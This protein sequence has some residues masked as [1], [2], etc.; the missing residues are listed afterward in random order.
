MLDKE[1]ES[2]SAAELRLLA[3]AR[4]AFSAFLNLHFLN[5][6]DGA[7][8]DEIRSAGYKS[9]LEQFAQD[10]DVQAEISEGARLMLEFIVGNAGVEAKQ[11]SETLGIDRTRLY[12][13]VSPAYGP[14]PPYE[15]EWSGDSVNLPEFLQKLA[16]SYHQDGLAGA[17][18]THDRL[19]YVGVEL[20]YVEF[21]AQQEAVQLESGDLAAA[22]QL[23]ERQNLFFQGHLVA[24]VPKFVEKALEYARTDFY[25]G[26][27]H[28]LRGFLLEQGGLLPLLLS[29]AGE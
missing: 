10:V 15:A 4:A 20:A 1:D 28:M 13:G 8:V 19:D 16:R 9:M 7:F 3:E 14:P 27:L 18:D 12:R 29:D 23:L 17:D 2:I 22:R 21:L 26:H 11:L 24:W 6:P 5:L 25:R